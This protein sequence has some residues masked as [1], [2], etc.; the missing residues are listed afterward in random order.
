MKGIFAYRKA[1]GGE[2]PSALLCSDGQPELGA[3]SI[4]STRETF[5]SYVIGITA[6]SQNLM[7]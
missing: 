4:D 1:T 5:G 2:I 7:V 6:Y 3:I